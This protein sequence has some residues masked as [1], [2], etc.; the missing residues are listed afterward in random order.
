LDEWVTLGALEQVLNA[1]HPDY[2][3]KAGFA[4]LKSILRALAD[5]FELDLAA[6]GKT[7]Q[8]RRRKP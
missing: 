5:H 8:V 2:L 4:S 3:D 7:A 1:R 6:D